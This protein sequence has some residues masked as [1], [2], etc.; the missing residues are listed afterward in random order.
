MRMTQVK[1]KILEEREE[2]VVAAPRR[3]LIRRRAKKLTHLFLNWKKKK[4]VD[5]LQRRRSIQFKD[6]DIA[7]SQAWGSPYF[8]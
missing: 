7:T 8:H 1:V 5:R 2:W 3:N 6:G 4:N